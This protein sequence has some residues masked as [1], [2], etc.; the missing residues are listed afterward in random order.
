M[1]HISDNKFVLYDKF[2]CT[3]TLILKL[4]KWKLDFSGMFNEI[5]NILKCLRWNM[6]DSISE[7][8][9]PKQTEIIKMT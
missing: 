6:T 5:T 4:L 8:T 9:N 3:I 1:K 7:M 2:E